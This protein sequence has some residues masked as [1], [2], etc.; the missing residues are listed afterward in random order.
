MED[1]DYK[2]FMLQ[3]DEFTHLSKNTIRRLYESMSK[4]YLE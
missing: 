3:L 4:E 1:D 2:D